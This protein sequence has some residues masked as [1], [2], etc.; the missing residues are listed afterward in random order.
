MTGIHRGRPAAGVQVT[1]WNERERA[2]KAFLKAG[3]RLVEVAGTP[4]FA[5]ALNPI[6]NQEARSEVGFYFNE[7]LIGDINLDFII[8]CKTTPR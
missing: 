7:F 5:H 2:W 4:F 8:D 1:T 6:N 3:K